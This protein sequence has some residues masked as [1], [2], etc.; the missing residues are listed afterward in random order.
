MKQILQVAN[1]YIHYPWTHP[2][3]AL[4]YGH[5]GSVS[6]NDRL[7]N[8]VKFSNGKFTVK[9]FGRL[10]KFKGRLPKIDAKQHMK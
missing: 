7:S 2:Q 10:R 9:H 1:R 6:L 8:P 3:K 5:L 4:L